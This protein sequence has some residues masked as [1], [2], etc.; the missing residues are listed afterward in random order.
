MRAGSADSQR[1]AAD[2]R[3]SMRLTLAGYAPKV[4]Y[5]LLL[6]LVLRLY[7]A[8][9]YG[10]FSLVLAILNF[11]MRL[12]ML[13][14]DKGLLLW[15]PRQ[16]PGR[17]REGLR[18]VLV[19]VVALNAVAALLIAAVLAPWIAHWAKKPEAV[20]T[21]RWMAVS[22]V[23]M[24]LM[25]VFIQTSNAR[26]RTEG[27]VLVKDGLVAVSFALLAVAFHYAGAGSPGL[28]LAHAGSVLIGL[29]VLY[30]LFRRHYADSPWTGPTLRP[31][32]ALVRLARP[33]WLTDLL[34]SAFN[35]LDVFMLAAL[36]DPVVTGL[37]QAAMQ[38]AQNVLAIRASFDHLVIV[39]VTEIHQGDDRERLTRG[40]TYT[41]RLIAS[42]VVPLAAGIVALTPWI[43]P[44]IGREFVDATHAV[45]I[46]VGFFVVHGTL[47]LN[48]A[49][50]IGAGRSALV[51][52]DTLAAMAVGGL[53]YALLVPPLGLDG[54]A[55]ATGLMYVSL[56][57]LFV[58]QAP[59]AVGHWPYDRSILPLL[60]R[61]AVAAAVM[62]ALWLSLQPHLGDL[63]RLCG[64]AGFAAV[65][66]P[67]L[68]RPAAP[69]H[70]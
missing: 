3:R 15:I 56:S 68:R 6:I 27:Q 40:F 60:A 8:G 13:G 9:P 47:G 70:A 7:G 64:L 29:V 58:V 52:L 20:T 54:A 66:L 5:P 50:L 30:A 67:G 59:R 26:R 14:L 48:Q 12:A 17:A 24:A 51:P 44:L 37:F 39:L 41:L 49:I 19:A 1:D 63:A 53:A 43:L 69:A 42:I 65:F 4:A 34:A 18:A 61:A 55:L 2:L 35:R 21:L 22:L 32:A 25:E 45:W 36:A 11:V 31:P 23:P 28:A 46:L 62:A 10:V 57:L 38:V 33:L 16:A